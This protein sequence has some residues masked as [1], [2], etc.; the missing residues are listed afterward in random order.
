M[1]T[2]LGSLLPEG[3]RNEIDKD[4]QREEELLWQRRLLFWLMFAY[5]KNTNWLK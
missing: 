3:H 5:F 1:N 4:M 2:S